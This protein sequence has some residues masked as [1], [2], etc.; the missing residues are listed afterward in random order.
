MPS[1]TLPLD[2]QSSNIAVLMVRILEY[3]LLLVVQLIV[4]SSIL[5][6][7]ECQDSV[8]QSLPLHGIATN[9][10]TTCRVSSSLLIINALI[11]V[12]DWP[13]VQRL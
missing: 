4:M 13:P 3:G 12:G 10:L 2:F 9:T 1:R 6:F 8:H 7:E 5:C 11:V